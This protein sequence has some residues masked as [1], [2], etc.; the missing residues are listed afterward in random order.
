MRGETE[1]ALPEIESRLDRVRDWWQRSQ[2]G[3]SVA[4]APNRTSLGRTLVSGLDI[5]EDANN[6][7]ENWQGCLDLLMETESAKR[8]LGENEVELAGTRF[9]Q[10]GP[11]L[12]LGRLDEAQRVLEGCLPVYRSAGAIA[13]E[14]RCLS[15]LANLWKER[16]EIGEAIAL[17]RQAL[18]VRNTLPDPSVRAN[19]HGNLGIYL[20]KAD[21]HDEASTHGLA[22]IVYSMLVGTGLDVSL[23]NLRNRARRALAA[24]E[25]YTLPPLEAILAHE[26]FAALRQFLD[27]HK[28]D[29]AALQAELDRLVDQ[30]H[31]EA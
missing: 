27:S 21:K 12:R 30:A 15:A 6:A 7:F 3:E 13:N 29:R 31:K 4:E 18:A 28:V 17:E 8:A 16:N 24:D 9:N 23:N 20:E 11:L 14:A 10:Y 5:A 22:D 2:A 26:E 25:R 19:S 1:T